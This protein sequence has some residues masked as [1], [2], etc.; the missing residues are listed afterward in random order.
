MPSEV[1][2]QRP[3]R[4]SAEAC[5][6]A[7]DR[8]PL[9]LQARAVAADPRGA[10]VDDVADARHGERRLGDVRGQHDAAARVRPEDALLLGGGEARVE[11]QHLDV[12]SPSR[13]VSASAVS[14]ISR[15][16][17]RNTSTSPGASRSSSSTAS[18][19]ASISSRSR[20]ASG[21]RLDQR[22]VAHL[23]RVRAA[24]HLDDGRA[25]EVRG[26]AL[27]VDRRRG[28][29]QLQVGPPRAGCAR[30]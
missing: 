18:P 12:R 13:P 11:R 9:H 10:R 24:G 15:S 30:R 25:A 29:D 6:I 23:D 19:I 7:L 1:R 5:E 27:R 16:P 3:L 20:S 28:D 22:P 4:W 21:R 2:P 26:E 8:Q 17:L 14:R